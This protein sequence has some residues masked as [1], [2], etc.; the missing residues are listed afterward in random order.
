[1][2]DEIKLIID[3]IK[4]G[5]KNAYRNTLV[6]T[7][8]Q[9]Q[10][11]GAE[12]LFTVNVAQ[13]IGNLNDH[14]GEPYKIYIEAKTKIVA[15]DCL[16]VIKGTKAARGGFSI[17][18]ETIFRCNHAIPFI[19]RNGKIDIAVYRESDDCDF[20]DYV[21]FCVIE[22]KSF[23]PTRNLVVRDLK[24]NSELLRASG[25]TG[26]SSIQVGVFSAAHQ[27]RNFKN[28]EEI[29]SETREIISNYKNWCSEIG[30]TSDL[31][32]V[33]KGFLLSREMEGDITY[34]IDGSYIDTSTRHCF[35]GII[36]ILT[37]KKKNIQP[38]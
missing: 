1:M 7:G 37:L 29:I 8:D 18:K 13:A 2:T 35:I 6:F 31:D 15:R 10:K 3:K 17:N 19:E 36:V 27:I 9:T 32:I 11:F 4:L 26:K 5:M 12:Y 16:P 20:F 24:R 28:D 38:K 30:N 34:E 14:D 33:T 22:L 23:N 21:P 25:P